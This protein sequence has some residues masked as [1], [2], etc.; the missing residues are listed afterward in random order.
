MSRL[1][2]LIAKWEAEVEAEA[3]SFM[4]RDGMS[5][6]EAGDRARALVNARRE[7]AAE[8]RKSNAGWLECSL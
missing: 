3:C 1:E 8:N 2:E 7:Q 4:E 6:G 5:P